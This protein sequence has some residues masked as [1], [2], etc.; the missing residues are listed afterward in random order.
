MGKPDLALLAYRQAAELDVH[1]EE[2]RTALR[3][4]EAERNL[5]ADAH[6]KK[7]AQAFGKE[8]GNP[9]DFA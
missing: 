5:R 7:S 6:P 8:E 3:R 1:D 2:S 9:L 4:L